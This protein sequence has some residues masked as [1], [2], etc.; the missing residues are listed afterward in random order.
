MGF[1]KRALLSSI[2]AITATAAMAAVPTP[3][4]AY[5][6]SIQFATTATQTGARFTAGSGGIR[7]WQYCE[8]SSGQTN[9]YS[10]GP[11]VGIYA[12]SWTGTCY[13]IRNR[14]FDVY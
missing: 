13:I 4:Q 3:A 9:W 8:S 10:Y 6:S 14:G 1:V 12:W 11:W 2:A 5:P 7:A